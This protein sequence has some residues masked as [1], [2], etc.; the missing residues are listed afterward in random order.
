MPMKRNLTDA[1]VAKLAA[2]ES[3]R[4][5]VFD[6]QLPGFGV[7]VGT[8]GKRAFFVMYRAHGKLVRE[9]L[10]I[11]PAMQLNAARKAAA[12]SLEL[13]GSGADPRAERRTRAQ[14]SFTAVADEFIERYAQRHQKP[15]TLVE[16]K[17]YI[18]HNL[19]PA[20]NTTPIH[21]IRRS[22]VLRV[23]DAMVD[24]GTTTSANRCLATIRKLFNWCLERGYIEA[25][26]AAGIRPPGKEVSRARVLTAAELGAIWS[27]ADEIGYPAGR[28]LQMMIASG[29]QRLTDVAR[30]RRSEITGDVWRMV[31][32][33]KSDEP[34]TVPLSSLA[35]DVLADCPTF[36]GDYVFSTTAGKKHIQAFSK[37][38][39]DI[40]RRSQVEAWRFHDIR[41]TVATAF[42]EYLALPPHVA[43]AVQN[44]R[45]GAVSGVVAVY[46]RARYESDKRQALDAWAGYVRATLADNVVRIAG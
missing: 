6:I 17:R 9:T 42:G 12:K 18:E 26:P 2:P 23:L 16:T 41:R 15:R 24:R 27:A 21:R 30:M 40:D 7:R 32:P 45:G 19:K 4:T 3:G 14:N 8:S 28:W 46:N 35:L 10:G 44:R 36:K 43:E 25:S 34:H 1:L 29:G 11:Y 31:T 13:A 38:K 39:A 33:T 20:W 22:D 5:E 37:I